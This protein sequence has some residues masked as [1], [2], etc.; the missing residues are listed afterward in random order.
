MMVLKPMAFRM[1]GLSGSKA[2]VISEGEV[3]VCIF[4]TCALYFVSL[5]AT[6]ASIHQVYSTHSKQ[7][8]L[9]QDEWKLT[10]HF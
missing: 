5:V 4:Q 7:T 1:T 2:K 10:L 8:D 9:Y 6:M 3:G